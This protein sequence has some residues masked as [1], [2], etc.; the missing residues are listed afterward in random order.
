M[1]ETIRIMDRRGTLDLAIGEYV[2]LG[3]NETVYIFQAEA[4]ES[5]YEKVELTK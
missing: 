3:S 1:P 5:A 2:V 4:F